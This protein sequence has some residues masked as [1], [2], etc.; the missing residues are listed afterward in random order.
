MELVI[1][2]FHLLNSLSWH[3]LFLSRLIFLRGLIIIFRFLVII[4]F[5]LW[6]I[7]INVINIINWIIII[8]WSTDLVPLTFT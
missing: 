5:F 8:D 7:N 6:N 4:L 1:L 3:K 2:F